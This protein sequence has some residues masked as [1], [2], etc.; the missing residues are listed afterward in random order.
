MVFT[1]SFASVS[2]GKCALIGHTFVPIKLN[3]SVSF[4]ASR[5]KVCEDDVVPPTVESWA[6]HPVT[7]DASQLVLSLRRFIGEG[8]IGMTYIARVESASDA[9]GA[10][11]SNTLPSEVCIKVAKPTFSRSL[12][13]E[14][15]FYEQL[16]DCRGTSTAKCYGFFTV[17]LS[18]CKDSEGNAVTNIYPWKTSK[19][20]PEVD[21]DMDDDV[22]SQDH[23]VD[24][25][26]PEEFTDEHGFK[27][28]SSWNSWCPS[29]SPQ[30]V[31][32]LV[33]ERLG[34]QYYGQGR[35][36]AAHVANLR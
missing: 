3:A 19:V 24:D 12:A 26:R 31:A 8:R 33:L 28:N 36:P 23:L 6:P 16:G 21:S 9:S 15:W 5:H 7:S 11:V 27:T 4:P 20:P 29:I 13:R 2:L 22:P 10:D 35:E 30:T 1:P 18:E 25:I 32:I 34:G 14:A 17:P